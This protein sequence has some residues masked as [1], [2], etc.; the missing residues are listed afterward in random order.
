VCPSAWKK[1]KLLQNMPS[2]NPMYFVGSYL[3]DENN[4]FIKTPEK[5]RRFLV[6][7]GEPS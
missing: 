5:L 2:K 7:G 1:K 4:S 6:A 3:I